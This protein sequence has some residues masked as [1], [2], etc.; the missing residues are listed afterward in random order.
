MILERPF[1]FAFLLGSALVLHKEASAQPANDSL[2]AP[3]QI[4][5]DEAVQVALFDQPD[6][7]P[8]RGNRELMLATWFA[9]MGE[10]G[11][12]LGPLEEERIFGD[13]T[14][15][16]AYRQ[17]FRDTVDL[18]HCVG[19]AVQ[20]EVLWYASQGLMASRIQAFGPGT[21][22]TLLNGSTPSLL[23]GSPRPASVYTAQRGPM[24]SSWTARVRLPFVR[25]ELRDPKDGVLPPVLEV[26]ENHEPKPR[27]WRLE[28]RPWSD[29]LMARR[30]SE[31]G[32]Q[33]LD[34]HE[35]QAEHLENS[36]H[37]TEDW[38]FEPARF[39]LSARVVSIDWIDPERTVQYRV[40]FLD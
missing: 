8:I 7:R 15:S 5:F 24:R 33:R 3:T 31:S 14:K 37:L 36:V 10:L 20:R 4:W 35:L 27:Y 32:W 2:G 26:L 25:K 1:L 28:S 21:M 39:A 13:P 17:T 29:S 11:L 40:R 30:S 22:L 9:R 12:P 19:I 18:E 16:M 23:P 38:F 6:F 34:I